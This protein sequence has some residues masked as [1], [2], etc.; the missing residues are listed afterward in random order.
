MKYIDKNKQEP[1]SLT[2]HRLSAHA[3]YDNYKEKEDLKQAL[4]EEQGYLCCYCMQRIEQDKMRIE[5]WKPQ[6]K[7]PLLQLDYHNLLAA[8]QGNEGKP[9]DSEHCDKRK[10]D[11]EITIKPLD[12]TCETFIKYR[13]N[14]QIYSENSIINEELNKVLNLNLESLRKNRN[15]ALDAVKKGFNKKY[16]K[17]SWKIR[18][19]NREINRYTNKDYQG[20]YKPYCQYIIYFLNKKLA[21]AESR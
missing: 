15:A 18:D 19:I 9:R 2:A 20:K 14:G 5:H 7:Y 11:K 8:C 13:G 6:S 12:K 17:E 4:L 3:D 16:G 10:G 1:K 21:I